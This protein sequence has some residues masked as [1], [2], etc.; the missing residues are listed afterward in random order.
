MAKT[1]REYRITDESRLTKDAARALLESGFCTNTQI[2]LSQ[3]FDKYGS[4]DVTPI[5]GNKDVIMHFSVPNTSDDNRGPQYHLYAVT[6]LSANS[7]NVKLY[8][9]YETRYRN[10]K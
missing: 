4:P 10:I 8:K 3:A 2:S 9:S 5:F 6:N 1:F 7:N